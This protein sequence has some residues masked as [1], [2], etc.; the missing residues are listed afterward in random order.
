M[1]QRVEITYHG[2]CPQCGR[3]QNERRAERVDVIC[4]YCAHRNYKDEMIRRLKETDILKDMEIDIDNEI[5]T[6]GRYSFDLYRS[7]VIITGITGRKYVI[8]AVP[9][10][11]YT[12]TLSVEIFDKDSD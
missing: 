5:S 8:S 7:S 11:D 3:E 2:K 4:P 6:I 1:E 9:D 10:C 12:A